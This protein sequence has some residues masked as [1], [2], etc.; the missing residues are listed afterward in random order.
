[1]DIK[2]KNHIDHKQA[3]GEAFILAAGFGR[4]LMPLT[5]NIPKPLVEINRKPMIDYIF[6][7]LTTIGINKIYIN[8]HYQHKKMLEFIER[9]EISNIHISHES[10][11]LDTG[12]GIKNAID[13][14]TTQAILIINCDAI[15]LNNFSNL[16][17]DL[18]K[19]FNPD[20]MDA[21]L[22]FSPPKNAVGYS[23]NGDFIVAEDGIVI[24][25]DRSDKMVF[26]GISVLNT[27]TLELINSDTFSLVEIWSKLIKKRTCYGIVF[28]NIWYHAGNIEA[29]KLANQFFAR[30]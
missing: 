12:G 4:R 26:M 28:E 20:K 3:V 6:D 2:I 5:K 16:L 25:T 8:T 17:Q 24:D 21:L 15:L 30:N 14:N 27:K 18:L 22:A 10:R 7:A 23:G 19:Q 11:L 9:K 29:I 13:T 1:M